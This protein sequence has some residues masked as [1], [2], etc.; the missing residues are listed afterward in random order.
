MSDTNTPTND[1]LR[2]LPGEAARMEPLGQYTPPA[3]RPLP[4]VGQP[5]QA[6]GTEFHP[7][8]NKRRGLGLAQRTGIAALLLL[9]GAAVLVIVLRRRTRMSAEAFEPDPEEAAS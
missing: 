3:V 4:F 9:G 6:P 8:P 7:D 2:P 5:H 1:G